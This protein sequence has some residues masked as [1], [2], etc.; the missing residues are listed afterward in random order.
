VRLARYKTP[1]SAS[2][3][4]TVIA[5]V[6]RSPLRAACCRRSKPPRSPATGSPTL[7]RLC[8]PKTAPGRNPRQQRRQEH[9]TLFR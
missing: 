9:E 2:E 8:K 6:A 5:G 1:G 3:I 7:R 4:A